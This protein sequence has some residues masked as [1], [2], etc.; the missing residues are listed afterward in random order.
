MDGSRDR[1]LYL[2]HARMNDMELP[3]DKRAGARRIFETV[4]KQAA[5]RTLTELR[6]RLN[7][8]IRANDSDYIEK[9]QAEI[10]AYGY[11]K[12]YNRHENTSD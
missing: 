9:I 5:D 3:Y 8:A 4:R 1:D 12:G 2:L 11:R 7:R 6:R 10:K